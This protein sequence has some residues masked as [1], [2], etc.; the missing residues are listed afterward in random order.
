MMKKLFSF[1]LLT[2]YLLPVS[3]CFLYAATRIKT[4]EWNFGSYYSATDIK[5]WSAP[6]ITINLPD[7]IAPPPS[8]IKNAFVEIEYL[9]S[10][11]AAADTTNIDVYFSTGTSPGGPVDGITGPQIPDSSGESD[12]MCI[13]VDVTSKIVAWANQ[14]YS[15][16]VVITGPNCNMFSAKLYITYYYD[17]TAGTQIKTVRFPIFTSSVDGISGCASSE[18]QIISPANVPFKYRCDLPETGISLKQVWFEI[19]GYRLSGGG[20]TDGKVNVNISGYAGEPTMTLDGALIDTYK[21]RYLTSTGIPSGFATNTLQ[22]VYVNLSGYATCNVLGGEVVITYEYTNPAPG[23]YE[24]KTIYYF[25]SQSI[26]ITGAI[27]YFTIPVYLGEEDVVIE[28]IYAHIHGSFNRAIGTAQI[29][30]KIA[31]NP[32]TTRTYDLAIQPAVVSGFEFY[33][34]LSEGRS[35]WVQ[36]STV[37]IS[38]ITVR[39]L[40]GMGFELIITYKYTKEYKFTEYYKVFAGQTANEVASAGV[41]NYTSN[42]FFP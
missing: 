28:R 16:R 30:S 32:L 21:F 17:D 6:Y 29:E 36:G 33:Y 37:N 8:P 19:R 38:W 22:T 7:A 14:V 25:H 15:L 27:E 12:P 5:N 35:Y 11:G 34:D 9:A 1:I 18:S 26:G 24:L 31:G 13:R 41:Y 10:A 42:I 39:A 40:G 3:C 4:V 23:S 2:C 20:A